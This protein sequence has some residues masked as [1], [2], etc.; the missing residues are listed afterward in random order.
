M[1]NGC[2]CCTVRGDLVVALKKLHSKVSLFDAIIIE[3]TGLADQHRQSAA[4]S[5]CPCPGRLGR[6]ASDKGCST[7]SGGTREPYRPQW[8]L[9]VRPSARATAANATAFDHPG[10]PCSGGADLLRGRRDTGTYPNPNPDPNP[11]FADDE[12]QALCLFWPIHLLWTM[13][14]GALHARRHHHGRRR[15]AHSRAPRRREARGRRER[16]RRAGRST[17][18]GCRLYTHGY[19][20][21]RARPASRRR[22][23]PMCS[24][25]P[26]GSFQRKCCDVC[27]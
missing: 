14:T 23:H 22:S 21:I 4:P 26:G 20:L 1:M 27:V 8:Q 15:Q 12:T 19:S 25:P 7:Y 9:V 13:R 18:Y 2:I 5:S 3:T 16:G 11:N 24:E 6:T 10:R 17:T